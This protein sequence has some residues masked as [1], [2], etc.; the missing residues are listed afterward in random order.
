MVNYDELREK[1]TALFKEKECG[2]IMIRLSWHDAGTYDKESK[3]GGP[4]GCQRHEG[5]GEAAHGANA[6]LNVARQLLA[7]LKKEYEEVSHADFWALAGAVAV[8]AMGGPRVEFRAGRKD[9]GV[10]ACVEDGRLPD[11]AQG[12]QHLR[13]IFYR[14][15]FNDR[16]IVV[17]SG[18][19]SVG[20]THEDRSGFKGPWTEEPLKFDNTYFSLL[21]ERTWEEEKAPNGNPQ[22][23]DKETGKC[24]MLPSDLA[25]IQDEK[26]KPFVEE[27]AKDQDLFFKEFAT[28][29][30]R[31][32]ELGVQF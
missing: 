27:F 20:R 11:A 9:A 25:L 14:M 29:F 24:V 4:R 15:G 17:L 28:Q 3:T 16:E 31:L 6:G 7:D 23:R 19:H 8:E 13:D 21:L 30:Q 32:Q 2:P 26:M 5:T 1:L 12:A 18:A 10:E 22:F